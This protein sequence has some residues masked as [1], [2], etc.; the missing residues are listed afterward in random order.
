MENT[1]NGKAHKMPMTPAERQR[2]CREKKGRRFCVT[3]FLSADELAQ[4]NEAWQLQRSEGI[5][6]DF[7][8]AAL[9]QGVKFRANSGNGKKI[10]GT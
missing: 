8:A 5:K 7:L 9:L 3:V 1:K 6:G 10:K 4:L 2:K